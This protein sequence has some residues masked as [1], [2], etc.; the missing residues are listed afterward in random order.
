RLG[1]L[2]GD[3]AALRGDRLRDAV[4]RGDEVRHRL[5]AV[6]GERRGEQRAA[7][8]GELRSGEPGGRLR[9]VEIADR[10]DVDRARDAG[11]LGTGEPLGDAELVG[12]LA[13]R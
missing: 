3:R 9:E 11:E 1:D 10:G 7:D 2:A 5:L 13:Q 6:V 12:E 8:R 4:N